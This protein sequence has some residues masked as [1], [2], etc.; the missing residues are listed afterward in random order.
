MCPSDV[1]V[2][3]DLQVKRRKTVCREVDVFVGH[4]LQQVTQVSQLFT[5]YTNKN[6]N[7]NE[8]SVQR[9]R[10]HCALTVLRQSQ[11]FSPCHRPPSRRCRTGKISSAR[12]GHYLHLQTQFGE[13]WC[14]QFRV[15][16]VTDPRTNKQT[17]RGD[18][19]TLRCSLAHSVITWI[20]LS[21]AHTFIKTIQSPLI[22]S[23][24][25]TSN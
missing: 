18:Y 11:K 16:M 6:K 5:L 15:I 2:A 21:R 19:S 10:K 12:D 7:M 8:K 23:T 22:Q 17:D 4:F 24:Y 9:R 13:H 25:R 1:V 14:T 20:A 3:N